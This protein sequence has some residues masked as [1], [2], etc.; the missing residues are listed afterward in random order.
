LELLHE[1]SVERCPED[2][3]VI[4]LLEA[5]PGY[6]RQALLTESAAFVERMR[7]WLYLRA[8]QQTP[9]QGQ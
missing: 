3:Q 6:T 2:L 4:M 5:F 8:L 7:Q 9:P 1:H